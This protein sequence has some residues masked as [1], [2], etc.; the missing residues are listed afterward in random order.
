MQEQIQGIGTIG[1][2]VYVLIE[3]A[4]RAGFPSRYAALLSLVLG[5]VIGAASFLI[6]GKPWYAGLAEGFWG[7]A[8]AS[9]IYSGTK[10]AFTPETVSYSEDPALRPNC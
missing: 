5:L 10:A 7:A 8:S 1:L 3:V 6:L 4:K 2:A 9:G